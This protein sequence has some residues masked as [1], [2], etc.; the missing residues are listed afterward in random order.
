VTSQPVTRVACLTPP[1]RGAIATLGLHGPL[2]WDVVRQLFRTRR[3]AELPASPRAGRT[4]FGRIGTDISDEVILAVKQTEP[5]LSL[6]VHCH[7]GR[8]AVRWL[9]DLFRARG[10]EVCSSDDFLRASVSNPLRAEA[11]LALMHAPTIRTAAILLDQ[12]HGAFENA[13]ADIVA[14]LD[15]GDAAA[16]KAQLAEL[17]RYIPLGRHLTTPW[18]V[19]VAGAP[20]VGK[21]SL[22]NAL[23]GYQR[24]VVAAT[25]GT[26]RD[27]VTVSLAV[28]GWPVELADT[29]GQREGDE[30]LEKAGIQRAREAAVAAD[31][32]L[33]VLDASTEPAWPDAG[34]G[35][36]QLIVNKVDLPPAWDLNLAKG[37]VR[38]SA[39][40]GEGLQELCAALSGW[41]VP[42]IPR[43]GTAMPFLK[44]HFNALD[45]ASRSMTVDQAEE[46]RACL[47][48]L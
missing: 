2:A 31:L 12:Y 44:R 33:W 23:A 26:T 36:V 21:S 25:P 19:T 38:V 48:T 10:L 14:S 18:R 24:S 6:E 16:A 37:A 40:T 8:E 17:A 43:A 9:V 5:V 4:W 34:A 27:V 20:N 41:L 46:A 35:R 22:V 45:D 13:V 7:G 15:R 39:Q 47:R 28:D 3:G 42:E 29:A 30:S 1:G 32:C 11:A